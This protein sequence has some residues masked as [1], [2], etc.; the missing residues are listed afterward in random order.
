RIAGAP[1]GVKG[2][3]LFLVPRWRVHADGT[4]AERNDVRLAGVNHKMGQRGSVNTFLKFGETGDCHGYLVGEPHQGLG[5][6]FHMMNEERIGVG[7]GAVLQGSVGYLHS[8][9]YAKERKQ[10]RHPEQKDPAS[11][12]VALI[13]HADVRRMLLQQKCYTEGALALA[14]YSAQLIDVRDNDPDAD[15]VRDAKLLLELIT[16]I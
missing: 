6:M 8:L 10:G 13:E 5:Y 9:E 1:A 15:K 4:R 11:P 2:I 3:S 14:F 12:P 7:M 16:P